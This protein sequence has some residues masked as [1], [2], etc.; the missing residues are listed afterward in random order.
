MVEYI[1]ALRIACRVIT[2]FLPV[3]L[4]NIFLEM[5]LLNIADTVFAPLS[6]P[7]FPFLCAPPPALRA[8]APHGLHLQLKD[9]PQDTG[10]DTTELASFQGGFLQRMNRCQSVKAQVLL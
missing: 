9:C 6:S 3:H 1:V 5:E 8:F 10:A 2:V 7:F 4:W